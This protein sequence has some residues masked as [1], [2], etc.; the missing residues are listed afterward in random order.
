MRHVVPVLPSKRKTRPGDAG[1]LDRR[2]VLRLVAGAAALPAVTRT[3][4]A[5]TYPSRSVHLVV[6]VT[7][8]EGLHQWD[9][10]AIDRVVPDAERIAE[11]LAE[12][13]LEHELSRLGAEGMTATGEVVE[14]DPVERVRVLLAEQQVDGVVVATL[15]HR[16]SRWLVMDLPHRLTRASSVPVVHLEADAGPSL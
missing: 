12:G 3:A 1:A 6:P 16:L 5:D 4:R 13:R 9:Y 10:P 11:A 15:P 7:Q 8:T 2:T 14:A